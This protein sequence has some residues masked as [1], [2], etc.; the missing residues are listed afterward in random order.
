LVDLG[1]DDGMNVFAE[2]GVT[3]WMVA[4]EGNNHNKNN[5]NNFRISY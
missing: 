5:W 2:Y 1:I 3:G 4:Y